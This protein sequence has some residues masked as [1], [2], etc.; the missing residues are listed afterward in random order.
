MSVLFLHH[1][2]IIFVSAIIFET[3]ARS[4]VLSDALLIFQ[5]SKKS[6]RLMMSRR[7]SDHWKGL[8]L[9][10]YSICIFGASLKMF[11][12]ICLLF[13]LAF[14][15]SLIFPEYLEVFLTFS[16]SC[17][18]LLAIFFCAYIKKKRRI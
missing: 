12:A 5:I 16:G 14:L 4:Q 2:L 6:L 11:F 13:L 15:P 1:L 3:A 8:A 18:S 7:I 17:V 10:S 9:S